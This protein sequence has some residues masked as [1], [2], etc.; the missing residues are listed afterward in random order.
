[1]HDLRRMNACM[2]HVMMFGLATSGLKSSI[3]LFSSE[4]RIG[5]RIICHHGCG[6]S[7]QCNVRES[8]RKAAAEKTIVRNMQA[9][10][11]CVTRNIYDMAP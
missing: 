4:I 1:M 11:T 8:A 3:D 9:G 7:G 6:R 2:V 10:G 5:F